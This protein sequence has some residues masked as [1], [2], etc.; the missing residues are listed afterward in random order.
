MSITINRVII[1]KMSRVTY[2]LTFP[3]CSIQFLE[4]I[5]N[6]NKEKSR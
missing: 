3:L 5:K 2:C 6:N 1:N 4:D